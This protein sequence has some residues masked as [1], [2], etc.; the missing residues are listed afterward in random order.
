MTHICEGA[1]DNTAWFNNQP[2]GLVY[3]GNVAYKYKGTMPSN[4]GI[5]LKEGTVGIADAAFQYCLGLMG[6]IIPNSVTSIGE[7]A[8]VGA[9]DYDF[10]NYIESVGIIC[11]G[12]TP[13]NIEYSF[14]KF[15]YQNAMLS[16]PKGSIDAYKNARGWE[17]FEMIYDYEFEEL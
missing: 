9:F 4:T 3:A 2:D 17:N 7:D 16:V 11:K 10:Y 8:F 6:I 14:D 13:P 12:N 5:T 1:F 15:T